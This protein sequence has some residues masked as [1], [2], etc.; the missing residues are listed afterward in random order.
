MHCTLNHYVFEV[1]LHLRCFSDHLND[2]FDDKDDKEQIVSKLKNMA[3]LSVQA[4]GRIQTD[5]NCIDNYDCGDQVV[6]PAACDNL[7]SPEH[8]CSFY[9]KFLI[10]S[11]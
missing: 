7:L 1:I 9:Y 5:N 11:R 2:C 8:R 4:I 10:V 3:V 6:E